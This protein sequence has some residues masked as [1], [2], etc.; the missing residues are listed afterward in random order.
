MRIPRRSRFHPSFPLDPRPR[1][2]KAWRRRHGIVGPSDG[3]GYRPGALRVR[4][5]GRGGAVATTNPI[6][7]VTRVPVGGFGSST[8]VFGNQGADMEEAPRG[9]DLVLRLGDGTLRF[10]TAEA[11]YGT[12]GMQ[13]ANAIAVREPCVHW[14]G[15]KAL[16]SMVVGAPTQQ[17]QVGTYR[18]Q[19]YEVT[20]FGSGEVASIRK[21]AGQP[22]EFDNVSPIYATDGRILFTSDRPPSGALHHFPRST[23]TSPRRPWRASIRWTR[24]AER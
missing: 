24:R 11:G 20:G 8:A 7:F 6:L 5:D 18:W 15:T 14:S 23:S 13:G 10:L 16:F 21:I 17:Y 19:I 9:G 3:P 12:D 1:P 2:S 4:G 22:A